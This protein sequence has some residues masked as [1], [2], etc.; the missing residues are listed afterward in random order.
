MGSIKKAYDFLCE[1]TKPDY[2]AVNLS[3]I[4]DELRWVKQGVNNTAYFAWQR[5]SK[6][7]SRPDDYWLAAIAHLAL[8][9]HGQVVFAWGVG[10]ELRFNPANGLEIDADDAVVIER[11]LRFSGCLID[12]PQN[13]ATTRYFADE[14]RKKVVQ[15]SS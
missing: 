12:Y 8:S 13:H 14:V 1:I 2:S 11:G 5:D 3:K 10:D 7:L 15:Q 6:R 4:S 9:Q